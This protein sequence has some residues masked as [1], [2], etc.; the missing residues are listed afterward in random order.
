MGLSPD[1]LLCML[2]RPPA[3]YGTGNKPNIKQGLYLLPQALPTLARVIEKKGALPIVIDFEVNGWMLNEFLVEFQKT[4]P[5]ILF[6]TTSTLS[7]CYCREMVSAVRQVDNH[8]TIIFGGPHATYQWKSLLDE[9]I[10]DIVVLGEGEVALSQILDHYLHGRML[11]ECAGIAYM[12]DSGVPVANANCVITDNLSALGTP[13]YEYI[14]MKSYRERVG[15]S[16][17]EIVRG[18]PR[19][20]KFCLNT[21]YYPTMRYKPIVD[22]VKEF[23]LLI[24]TYGFEKLSVISPE[25][26]SDPGYVNKLLATLESLLRG[27]RVTWACA[28]TAMSLSPDVLEQMAKAHCR[29]IFI[30]VESGANEVQCAVG[31]KVDLSLLEDRM[32][33][34]KHAGIDVLASFILGL[35]GETEASAKQTIELAASLKEKYKF[36]KSIQ[37]NTFGPFPGTDIRE[38]LERYRCIIL[39]IDFAYYA[40]VPAVESDSFP[41]ETHYQLWHEVWKHFFPTYYDDYLEIER[42]ALAG[43]NPRLAAFCGH[44]SK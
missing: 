40:V 43:N 35:P 9:R 18:C 17:I 42:D 33:M 36:I 7:F 32:S 20:C 6:F 12:D 30:G 44:T 4:A 25:L 29:S 34:V 24:E 13:A 27:T 31:S 14:D 38:D 11:S 37:F 23:E 15:K 41:R 39:P 10:A 1:Q 3:G 5:D 19:G 16:S 22:V 26:V 28:T 8:V 2:V 21:K